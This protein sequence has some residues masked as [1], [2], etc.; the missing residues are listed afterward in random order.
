MN[1]TTESG[2]HYGVTDQSLV[3]RAPAWHSRVVYL[4]DAIEQLAY[5]CGDVVLK[6]ETEEM[7]IQTW[8]ERVMAG[9]GFD[10]PDDV[11]HHLH[12]AEIEGGEGSASAIQ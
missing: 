1:R 2:I 8:A 10:I 12:P 7:T 11:A 5:C 6:T 3:L 9:R 4:E